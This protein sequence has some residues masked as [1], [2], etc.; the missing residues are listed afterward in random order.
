[1]KHQLTLDSW[2]AHKRQTS[3]KRQ[4][5]L[6]TATEQLSATIAEQLPAITELLSATTGEQLSP[7][8][9]QLPEATEQPPVA[10]FSE[11]CDG[12]CCSNELQPY[13]PKNA[14]VLK[15]LAKNKHNFIVAWFSQFSWL[16]VCLTHRCVFCKYCQYCAKHLLCD[17]KKPSPAW[18]SVSCD[19]ATDVA[20]REQF[21]LSARWVDEDYNVHEVPLG[22]FCPPNTIADI[23][24]TVLKDLLCC[25]STIEPLQGLG[26]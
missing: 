14:A 5:L 12:V 19:E 3:S 16:T 11:S 9:E 20:N 25:K 8:T 2:I 26:I 6:T 22:L 24:T 17:M 1:M 15:G 23:M 21:N 4:Q 7:T 18:F 10:E 13:Q